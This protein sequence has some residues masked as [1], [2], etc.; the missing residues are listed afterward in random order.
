MAT[1]VRRTYGSRRR[2]A[3]PAVN[4]DD[5][6]PTSQPSPTRSRP[7]TALDHGLHEPDH[8]NPFTLDNDSE[9]EIQF[10]RKVMSVAQIM[11]DSDDESDEDPEVAYKRMREEL[12]ATKALNEERTKEATAKEKVQALAQKKR[13]EASAQ[14][15]TEVEEVMRTS[16]Q[17][18]G[19]DSEDIEAELRMSS[20]KRAPRR[21][22][23]KKAIEEMH[24]ETERLQ[25][26]MTLAPEANVHIKLKMTDFLSRLGYKKST[27]VEETTTITETIDPVIDEPA[28][29]PIE[30]TAPAFSTAFAK[31][32]EESDDEEMPDLKTLLSQAKPVFSSPVPPTTTATPAE[33]ILSDSEDEAPLPSHLKSHKLLFA[34]RDQEKIQKDRRAAKFV[35]MARPESPT[36]VEARLER[37]RKATLLASVARQAKEERSEREAAMKAAGVQI[38]S[39]ADRQKEAIEIEDLVEKARLQAEELRKLEKREDKKKLAEEEGV[40]DESERDSDWSDHEHQDDDG[41]E[42]GSD[43]TSDD[44]QSDTEAPARPAIQRTA[45][46]LSERVISDD[47]EEPVIMQRKGPARNWIKRLVSGNESDEEDKENSQPDFQLSRSNAG[48]TQ[49]FEPTQVEDGDEAPVAAFAS[50]KFL[51]PFPIDSRADGLRCDEDVSADVTSQYQVNNFVPSSQP[52]FERPESCAPTQFSIFDPPSPDAPVEILSLKPSATQPTQIDDFDTQVDAIIGTAP[53]KLS[54]LRQA[55]EEATALPIVNPFRRKRQAMDEEQHQKSRKAFLDDRAVES[56]DEYAGLGGA[57]DEEPEDSAAVAAELA[58]MIDH[59]TEIED[60]EGQRRIA[61]FYAQKDL[62]QDEK[63]VNSLMNDINNGGLRRKR[64]AGLLDMEDSEDEEEEQARYKARQALMRARLL[65]SQDLTSLAENPKTRAFVDAMED[66]QATHSYIDITGEIEVVAETQDENAD[67]QIDDAE[68]MLPPK[69]KKAR[70]PIDIRSELSFLQDDDESESQSIHD[71]DPSFVPSL[72]R[73]RSSLSIEDRS[74]TSSTRESQYHD[75]RILARSDSMYAKLG[76]L[77]R[78]DSNTTVVSTGGAPMASK[79]AT[80]AV[81]YHAKLNRAAPLPK[82]RTKVR[83]KKAS[84]VA[85]FK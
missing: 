62:E 3:S 16:V 27:P 21:M 35:A 10:P 61:A 76:S 6:P 71:F 22:A 69:P 81:N 25:R 58:D 57:S 44:E 79:M 43:F 65:E 31:G 53:A 48:L 17:S 66:K 70:V 33:I 32:L 24:K 85:L 59:N 67:T 30:S 45:S 40:N 80:R 42:D 84:V 5:T 1:V 72:K 60:E 56:D 73:E 20:A 82:P 18:S 41:S 29:I 83:P 14:I 55:T 9:E 13:D 52:E 38:V 49:F 19:S 15:E 26:N 68:R 78:E 34:K 54:R 8:Y 37:Q 7:V 4:E 46:I 36:K 2:E 28:Q 64:G 63:L 23:S 50:P 75:P 39:A 74:N 12:A 11:Q 47:E 77:R 51:K